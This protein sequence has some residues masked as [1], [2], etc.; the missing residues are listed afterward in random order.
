M[1]DIS[2]KDTAPIFKLANFT[3]MY[4]T[5][6]K[7]FSVDFDLRV[8]FFSRLKECI[9]AHFPDMQEHRKGR[10]IYLV[11]LDDIGNT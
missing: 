4:T 2:K 8:L 1:E 7:Q 10:D 5:T 9:L 6:L 3:K 11:L